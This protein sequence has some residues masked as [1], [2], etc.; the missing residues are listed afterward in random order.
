MKI[1]RLVRGFARQ[2]SRANVNAYAA[3]TAF[4][5][6]LSLIPMIMLIC[7]VLAVTPIVQKSDLLT[8]ATIFPPS[9]TPLIV[10]LIENIY[11]STF[12]MISASAIVT[13]WSAGKGILALMRGLNA[14]NGVVEDRNY[15]VQRLIASFYLII[16]LVMVVFSLVVMVFGNL[17]ASVIVR[18]VPGM[19]SL[20]RL[21]L[22]F[23][24]IFSWCVMTLLFA[25]MYTF[26][27]NRRLR[28]TWQLPGAAFSAVT[29][30]VFSWGFSIYVRHS[31]GFDMY[32]SLTTIVILM[33]WLYFCFYLFLI[34]AHVNRF[35]TPFR[36]VREKQRIRKGNR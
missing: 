7:S 35:L 3:S 18:H 5:I 27:P 12:G 36:K 25:L 33:L 17:L 16:F 28:F 29:W 14:M 31:G 1:Y 24:G 6:F 34:G 13:V 8:A 20:F 21:L 19:E 22:H 11:D 4:F 23:R 30:N 2:M 26:I 9:I 32:G 15:V 10:G